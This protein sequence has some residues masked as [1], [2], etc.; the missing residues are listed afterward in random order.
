MLHAYSAP[1][2]KFSQISN[3]EKNKNLS[4]VDKVNICNT[5]SYFLG[6]RVQT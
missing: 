2:K 1:C 5:M 6:H 3:S 4:T